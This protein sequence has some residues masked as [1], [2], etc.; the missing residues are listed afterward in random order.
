MV[1]LYIIITSILTALAFFLLEKLAKCRKKA[2]VIM[3][4]NEI[5]ENALK[6]AGL[7]LNELMSRA[8]EQGYFNL[9][10]IDTA[11]LEA[12]GR[13]SFL[14]LPMKRQLNP[15]DFNFA[16]LREGIC[17]TVIENGKINERN[18]KKSGIT[19]QALTELLRQRGESEENIL[20]AT[21]N[22]A[23]RV[24]FFVRRA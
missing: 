11:I 13:V 7:S 4:E 15:K 9:G 8:R 12:S 19:R 22:E 17:K 18:L 24:D 14:P 2:I 5:D 3:S 6:K 21:V 20:L 23:G 1:Y 16:P 10:D